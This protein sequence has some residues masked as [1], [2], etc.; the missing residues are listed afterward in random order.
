LSRKRL[1]HAGIQQTA[2]PAAKKEK[3]RNAKTHRFAGMLNNTLP[4]SDSD[5]V[6]FC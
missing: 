1:Q 3:Q 4:G 6:H 5:R 2:T